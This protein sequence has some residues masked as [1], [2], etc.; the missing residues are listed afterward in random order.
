MIYF[1]SPCSLMIWV[2]WKKWYHL[3]HF[4]I[5]RYIKIIRKWY[6]WKEAIIYF[7][8]QYFSF[9]LYIISFT[10]YLYIAFS[11][12]LSCKIGHQIISKIVIVIYVRHL[13]ICIFALFIAFIFVLFGVRNMTIMLLIY[14]IFLK[15]WCYYIFCLK[16][17]YPFLI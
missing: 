14:K 7:S 6:Y 5:K 17:W 1:V 13:L 2:I 15:I 11:I 4:H 8:L 12:R 16:L 10:L 9:T 3:I